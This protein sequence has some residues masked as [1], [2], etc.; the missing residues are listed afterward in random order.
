MLRCSAHFRP[1]YRCNNKPPDNCFE[2]LS[3]GDP[4]T[5]YSEQTSVFLRRVII[6]YM[7][8]A[9]CAVRRQLRKGK[10]GV[11]C[12]ICLI[13]GTSE[14]QLTNLTGCLWEIMLSYK[15]DL[16]HA[17]GKKKIL[18]NTSDLLK[19]GLLGNTWAVNILPVILPLEMARV[20]K[21]KHS[22]VLT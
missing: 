11:S 10:C 19:W 20:W 6:L 21:K 1:H 16:Y 12:V 13:K 8:T 14:N 7:N 4:L 15:P 22:L 2:T 17:L 5:L 9:A 18:N 3:E